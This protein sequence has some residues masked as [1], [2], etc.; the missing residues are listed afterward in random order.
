MYMA[1]QR[2]QPTEPCQQ[3]WAVAWQ[4][5]ALAL[6]FYYTTWAETDS[7]RSLLAPAAMAVLL[8][9]FSSDYGDFARVLL[10]KPFK[11]L[12][13]R[14]YSLFM[15]QAALMFIGHEA[16]LWSKRFALSSF[17]ATLVGTV[18]AAVYLVLLLVISDWTYRNIEQ[19]F[20]RGARPAAGKENAGL[21]SASSRAVQG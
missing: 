15:N 20:G 12:S 13:Q 4:A 17:N 21:E 19:R 14:A 18:A 7:A 3:R 2:F 8:W 9:A 5:A 10:A 16:A 1:W 11:W 6:F